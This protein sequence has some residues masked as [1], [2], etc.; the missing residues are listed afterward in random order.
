MGVR[1]AVVWAQ[2]HPERVSGLVLVDLDVMPRKQPKVATP[3]QDARSWSRLLTFRQQHHASEADAR[4]EL[5]AFGYRPSK[6]DEWIAAGAIRQNG[7]DDG[8]SYEILIHPLAGWL[9][10]RHILPSERPCRAWC[11]LP[12]SIPVHLLMGGAGHTQVEPEHIEAMRQ[13]RPD[14]VTF[15]VEQIDDAGHSLHKTHPRLVARALERM[16]VQK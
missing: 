8:G 11:A 3:E 9:T 2:L 13:A 15:V 6:I 4:R 1:I 14:P 5:A 16:L 12:L 7:G 10:R